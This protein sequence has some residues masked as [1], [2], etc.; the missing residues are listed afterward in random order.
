MTRFTK[1][2]DFNGYDLS[3]GRY[4]AGYAKEILLAG[5][6]LLKFTLE[7][8]SQVF[9]VHL[10]IGFPQSIY[11]D[12]DTK[13]D[14]FQYFIENYSRHLSLCEL[15]HEYLWV[16]EIGDERQRLHYH[17]LLLFN[18]HRLQFFS[19]DEICQA[20]KYWQRA[21]ERCHGVFEILPPL[22]VAKDNVKILRG[23]TGLFERAMNKFAY[24]AKL[25]TKSLNSHNV[26]CWGR[27]QCH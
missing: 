20:R 25:K 19:E 12:K 22:H 5:E 1:V 23:S 13:N 9:L 4:E 7:R 2:Q 16:R 15:D 11:V 26:R 24:L 10:T 14:C 17:L 18:G 8:H 21:L 3:N 27:S 6:N